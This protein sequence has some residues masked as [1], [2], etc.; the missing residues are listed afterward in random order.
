MIAR[1]VSDGKI[2]H[3]I[4]LL[5]KA[6]VME[7]GQINIDDTGTPQGGVISPLLANIYLDQM[8]KGW[9]S[10]NQYARLIRYTD[11]LVIMTKY[12]AEKLYPKLQSLIENLKL[13]FN[14]K[15][16]R[17]ID[18]GKESFDFLGFSFKKTLNRQKTKKVAYLWVSQKAD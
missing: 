3:L 12:K 7:E 10:L 1:R 8:Y 16:T 14:Q 17:I 9:K 15:K 4:K 13:R 18:A 11:V 2:L 5:L 6:G